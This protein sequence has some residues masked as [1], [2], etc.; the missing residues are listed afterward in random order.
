MAE[1]GLVGGGRAASAV[2]VQ[3]NVC[4]RACV[5]ACAVGVNAGGGGGG[6]CALAQRR[7]GRG[8]KV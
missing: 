4:V 2:G 3:G 6:R 7:P 5:R 8:C 1:R